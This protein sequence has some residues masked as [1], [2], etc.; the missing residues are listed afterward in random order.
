MNKVLRRIVTAMLPVGFVWFVFS[1]TRIRD[2][3][4]ADDVSTG[5]RSPQSF[6][7]AKA[8]QVRGDNDLEMKLIWCPPGRFKMGTPADQPRLGV[9]EKQVE[10]TLTT[11]FWLGSTEVT[12]EQ[13]MT[14]MGLGSSPW[15]GKSVI[16]RDGPDLPVIYVSWNDAMAFCA[17]LT[18]RE[19][20]AGRLPEHSH[21]TLPT[22]AEWEYA[23]R[24]GTTT[25]FSFGDDFS[26]LTDYG[27]ARK[28]HGPGGSSPRERDFHP[29]AKKLP[30]PW[31][32]FDMHG[33]VCEW[34]RDLYNE[35][36]PEIGRAHV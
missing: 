15:Q 34:C 19:K 32:F 18:E 12:Q 1:A 25:L 36:L 33:N 9:G 30:N 7:G 28:H 29:V 4:Q 35:T 22:E 23:C 17:K 20:G 31:G 6:A 27:W 5:K 13:W 24:A 16:V 8:G 10:V 11:G 3:A 26:K 14:V 21:Y 2:R